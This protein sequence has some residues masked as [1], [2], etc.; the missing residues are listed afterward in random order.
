MQ[1]ILCTIMLS[2][3]TLSVSAQK[4]IN[5]Y[6]PKS[7]YEK[8]LLLFENKH[9]ASAIECFEKYISSVDDKKQE[10]VVMAKYYEAA[11]TLF[12]DET[13]GENKITSFIKENPTALVADQAKLLY[14]NYLF[15]NRKYRDALKTYSNINSSNLS[16]EEQDEPD[17]K[18]AYCHYQTQNIANATPLFEKLTK[19]EHA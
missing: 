2:L 16:K 1:K 4:E 15:K 14:A 3:A 9:Y 10:N 13:D 6:N 12:L 7:F 5:Q 8:G 11:S 19:S 18:Q 17:F